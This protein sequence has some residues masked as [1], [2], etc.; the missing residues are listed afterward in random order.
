MELP[1]EVLTMVSK[2]DLDTALRMCC[3]SPFFVNEYLKARDIYFKAANPKE[4]ISSN[5]I[6]ELQYL[7]DHGYKLNNTIASHWYFIFAFD[8]SID[9]RTNV[10][11]LLAKYIA[12]LKNGNLAESFLRRA[13][14]FDMTFIYDLFFKCWKEYTGLH[15]TYKI[16]VDDYMSSF[17]EYAMF[18]MQN[19]S[20]LKALHNNGCNLKNKEYLKYFRNYLGYFTNRKGGLVAPHLVSPDTHN[21]S[22]IYSTFKILGGDPEDCKHL[23]IKY[24]LPIPDELIYD[25]EFPPLH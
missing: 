24:K 3:I 1:N 18:E 21:S 9:Y 10:I 22:E 8:I 16:Y 14:K 23:L 7:Y 17:E 13:F 19:M 11:P 6:K 25:I 2:V 15:L 4:L 5:N 12:R 20:M